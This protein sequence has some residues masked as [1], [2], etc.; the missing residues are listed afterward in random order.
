[1][2]TGPSL[3]PS[4]RPRR[5]TRTNKLFDNLSSPGH[6]PLMSAMP[7]DMPEH[8]MSDEQHDAIAA[9]KL[10]CRE[11]NGHGG[12]GPDD[13]EHCYGTGQ[14]QTPEQLATH[15]EIARELAAEAA[16]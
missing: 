6:A 3:P 2:W 5:E 13:C 4:L 14:I 7:D 11:C 15:A 16:A 12:C 8:E 10:R 1:M 9:A